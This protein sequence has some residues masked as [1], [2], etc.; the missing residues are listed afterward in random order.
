MGADRAP[1]RLEDLKQ[2]LFAL[3][4]IDLTQLALLRAARLESGGRERFPAPS[5]SI[6]R[7]C[8]SGQRTFPALRAFHNT[9][10]SV[11]TMP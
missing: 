2:E 7:K 4:R 11:Y 10:L 8:F 5:L 3:A 9:Y 6:A 1:H